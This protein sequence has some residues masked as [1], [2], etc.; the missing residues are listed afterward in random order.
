MCMEGNS[1]LILFI[2]N[3]IKNLKTQ[4]HKHIWPHTFASQGK[5]MLYQEW[6]LEVQVT[7]CFVAITYI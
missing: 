7:Q 5:W 3:L 2:T 6:A 1:T 4:V